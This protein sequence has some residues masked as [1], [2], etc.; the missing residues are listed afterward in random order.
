M[1]NS[2][3]E[4]IVKKEAEEL[5]NSKIKKEKAAVKKPRIKKEKLVV[6]EPVIVEEVQ[7]IVYK[8]PVEVTVDSVTVAEEKADTANKKTVFNLAEVIV[9][10]IIT[11]FFG[12]L[13]GAA[14]AYVKTEEAYESKDVFTNNKHIKAFV[15]SYN[16]LKRGFY[17]DFDDKE[18]IDAAIKG[19]VG[20][21]GDPYSQYLNVDESD[22]FEEDLSGEFIGMGAEITLNADGKVSVFSLF[23]GSPAEKVGVKQDDIIVKVNGK[24][25]EGLNTQQVA[26]LIKGDKIG[27]KV[28][29]TVL[30]DEK[31][32]D[33][34]IERGKIEIKSVYAEV[35]EK[36]GK[37]VGRLAISVFN[38]NTATQFLNKY[39][40]LKKENIDSLIVDVRG[41]GG[42]HLHVAR[43]IANLFLSKGE[44]IYRL[45]NRGSVTLENATD[46]RVIDLPVIVIADSGTASAAEILAAAIKENLDAEIVGEKTYGKGTVQRVHTLSTGASIKYT[47]NTW[48]TPKGN[49]IDKV[50]I[51]PTVKVSLDDSYY[52]N[53]INENDKQLQK[54]LELITK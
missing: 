32:Q 48:L 6:E 2:K 7:E 10:M 39:N 20:H 3:K 4:V 31:E 26:N 46:K 42:G 15:D 49:A 9:V 19:M 5:K 21:L 11:A 54:A 28:T 44:V 38:N 23:E 43:D 45:D 24:S 12:A 30:R 14:V 36:N 16:E 33:F 53:P 52:Q 22:L 1:A 27:E 13:V 34:V 50:G 25:V 35:L 29:V 37:K 47:V 8:K 41:N 40:E 51:E 18:L 17:A